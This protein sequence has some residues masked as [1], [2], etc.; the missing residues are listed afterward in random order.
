MQCPNSDIRMYTFKRTMITAAYC[1]Y[2]SVIVFIL[3]TST[4]ITSV[5]CSVCEPLY[6]AI[7]PREKITRMK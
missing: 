1:V 3:C 6:H 2:I 7:I 4:V 5:Y